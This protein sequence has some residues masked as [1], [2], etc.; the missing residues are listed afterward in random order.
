[1][2]LARHHSLFKEGRIEASLDEHRDI[3][4]ALRAGD[5]VAAQQRMRE[6]I[7]QGREAAMR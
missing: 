3:M 4:A 7:A 1:M 5:P 6:H 2:K